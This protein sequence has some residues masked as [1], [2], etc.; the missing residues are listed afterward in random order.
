MKTARMGERVQCGSPPVIIDV[1][2]VV[3]TLGTGKANWLRVGNSLEL[4]LRLPA[5][6][7]RADR[8]V[9][10]LIGGGGSA[11]WADGSI[12]SRNCGISLRPEAAHILAH[13]VEEVGSEA[14]LR[15]ATE[16]ISGDVQETA[17]GSRLRWLSH[18]GVPV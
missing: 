8:G 15:D 5:A 3:A 9:D 6:R 11:E 16:L 14:V 7:A 2:E 17:V 1:L 13:D 10:R 18:E 4:L 12:A